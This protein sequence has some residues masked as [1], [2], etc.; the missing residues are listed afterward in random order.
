MNSNSKTFLGVAEKSTALTN[1]YLRSVYNWMAAG[2]LITAIMAYSV[3]TVPALAA[4]VFSSKWTFYGLII[5]QVALVF[6]ISGAI[7]R[8]SAGAATG[9][10]L[11]Y[12]ALN[13]ATLSVLLLVYTSTS[14]VQAFVTAS[15]MF[16]A[17]SLY[18]LITKRDLTS[19]GSFCMMGLFGIIIA[20]IVNM[21]WPSTMM[22]FI[23]SCV[24]VVVFLGL[25][26]YD[27]QRL[28]AMGESAPEGDATAMRRGV[29]LGALT[30]YLDFINLFIMLLR[31]TGD[32]R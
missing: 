29:I 28:R 23:I 30:L 26:A 5:A 8:L 9:I 17:M 18:G 14:V 19:I 2:L 24:G 12:S 7:Q 10:F 3:V 13:G 15:G 11:L 1:A 20:S 27:T 21:I 6:T 31:L 4:I 22:N 25:T 32:R 16:V